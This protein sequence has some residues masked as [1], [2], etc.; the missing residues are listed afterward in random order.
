MPRIKNDGAQ[1]PK[2]ITDERAVH[3]KVGGETRDKAKFDN[4]RVRYDWDV[5]SDAQGDKR[6][7]VGLGH[8]DGTNDIYA[9][10]DFNEE[11]GHLK[12]SVRGERHL[13]ENL[14]GRATYGRYADGDQFGEVGATVKGERGSLAVDV[15]GNERT[16]RVFGKASGRYKVGDDTTLR[17]MYSADNKKSPLWKLGARHRLG[18][19]HHVDAEG[20]FSRSLGNYARGEWLR[21]HPG[22]EVRD[23]LKLERSAKKGVKAS[24]EGH[25]YAEGRE[26]KEKLSYDDGR[27]KAE[28]KGK[29][30]TD[31]GHVKGVSHFE[32]REDGRWS[33]DVGGEVKEGRNLFG[34][35]VR[36]D[37]SGLKKVK[38][39]YGREIS[40]NWDAKLT[41]NVDSKGRWDLQSEAKREFEND[42][43]LKEKVKIDS[44]GKRTYTH[45]VS[46]TFVEDKAR[47]GG[48]FSHDSEGMRKLTVDGGI[49]SETGKRHEADAM[50]MEDAD[51]NRTMRVGYDFDDRDGF[52]AGVDLGMEGSEKIVGVGMEREHVNKRGGDRVDAEW[53][54]EKGLSARGSTRRTID[55]QTE[56]EASV[57]R[58]LRTGEVKA[59]GAITHMAG[60]D[61]DVALRLGAE[62]SSKDNALGFN[63]GAS[64]RATEDKHGF[65]VNAGYQRDDKKERADFG[66]ALTSKRLF[67]L[68]EKSS[69]K[70]GG[71][72]EATKRAKVS[73][74][75]G[76]LGKLREDVLAEAG[77]DAAFVR[78][79]MKSKS[80]VD[81][82]VKVPIGVG[83]VDTGYKAGA[84]YELEFTK[85]ETDAKLG[86]SQD[87]KDLELPEGAEGLMALKAGESFAV[88]GEMTHAVRGGAGLGTTI[89]ASTVGSVGARAGGKMT[90]ALKGT[91]RTEVTRGGDSSARMVVKAADS[92]TKGSGIEVFAGLN[93]NLP[94]MGGAGPAG[95]VATGLASGMIKKWVSVGASKTHE[96]TTGDERLLD[97]RIDLSH[98]EA[99]T[100]YEQAMKGDW[101]DLEA[102]SK[103]GHPG[104]QIDKS[105]VTD[106][107]EETDSLEAAGFGMSY[108]KTSGERLKSSD[109]SYKGRD[110]EVESDLD[111]NTTNKD[112]WFV[113]KDFQVRDFTRTVAAADGGDLANRKAEEHWLGWSNAK[114]DSFTSKEEIQG[115]LNLA[116]FV[117][118]EDLP[119]DLK[120]YDKKIGKLKDHR[121][122]WIGPRNELRKTE[123]KTEVMLSDAALDR[124]SG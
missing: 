13:T 68:G 120:K 41:G 97:A 52:K 45:S 27:L 14:D 95:D 92:T 63:V 107:E 88:K 119:S 29:Y 81:L 30:E 12:G 43:T 59:E 28:V 11:T 19:G 57:G 15:G 67:G 8:D 99:R 54:S 4:E 66:G 82:G 110:F 44:K 108:N 116:R 111:S 17:G 84:S 61:E 114:Y 56:L 112:G 100:A 77:D 5:Y 98:P 24:Y 22:G 89:G 9:K 7:K 94:T 83:Y 106:I 87:V 102:L 31:G 10:V 25:H 53:S 124:L 115:Q 71:S 118:G 62:G 20:G 86:K 74:G 16:G 38:A 3:K 32:R 65:G 93:P 58:N 123:V 79:G 47:V 60:E 55:D 34:G 6:G 64:R 49:T 26:L 122:L 91:T 50:V 40:D 103:A 42:V 117:A 51:G 46:K 18:T 35:R 104:V 21:K 48:A 39:V 73:T 76:A 36:K 33:G 105:I 72:V 2:P 90:Y 78:F 101:S 85:L 75:R 37:L 69:F 1:P 23:H 80:K 109:V 96:K 70:L 121:K 113:D